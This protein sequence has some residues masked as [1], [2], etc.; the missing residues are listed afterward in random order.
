LPGR[1]RGGSEVLPDAQVRDISSLKT[2]MQ[3]LQNVLKDVQN[4]LDQS[5]K[6]KG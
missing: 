5:E 4:R 6:K 2:Q 1:G 3:E